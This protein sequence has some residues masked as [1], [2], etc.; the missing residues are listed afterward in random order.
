MEAP[1]CYTPK[2]VAARWQVNVRTV[3]RWFETGKLRFIELPGGHRRIP[4]REVR[5]VERIHEGS[6]HDADSPLI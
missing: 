6:Q 3:Y 2:D 5:R 1:M 4:A